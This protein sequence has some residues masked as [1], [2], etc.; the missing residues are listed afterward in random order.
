MASF[1]FLTENRARLERKQQRE[2]QAKALLAAKDRQDLAIAAQEKQALANRAQS[3][4]QFA[5]SLSMEKQKFTLAQQ[6][7]NRAD[8]YNS[9]SINHLTSIQES[10]KL[11]N[12][13]NAMGLVSSGSLTPIDTAEPGSVVLNGQNYKPT[14]PETLDK[15]KLALL[16]QTAGIQDELVKNRN[17]ATTIALS[18]FLLGKSP[19]L[20]RQKAYDSLLNIGGDPKTL[21]FA[22]GQDQNSR[23]QLVD[24]RLSINDIMTKRNQAAVEFGKD[25]PQVQALDEQAKATIETY[26]ATMQA[27]ASPEELYKMGEAGTAYKMLLKKSKGDD[28]LSEVTAHLAKIG[29]SVSNTDPNFTQKVSRAAVTL[30]GDDPEKLTNLEYSMNSSFTRP[31]TINPFGGVL[32]QAQSGQPAPTAQPPTPQPSVPQPQAALTPENVVDVYSQQRAAQTGGPVSKEQAKKELR[33]LYD[34]GAIDPSKKEIVAQALGIKN[35]IGEAAKGFFGETTA[36][37]KE[38]AQARSKQLTEEVF[39]NAPKN[40]DERRKFLA[41]KKKARIE[42]N[43]VYQAK[44][45]AEKEAAWKVKLD[46][47]LKK[48]K[49]EGEKIR[50][51]V[52]ADAKRKALYQ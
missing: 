35:A 34:Q 9:A 42:A 50:L 31:T 7:A 25:S 43:A 44:R 4:Q 24:M 28:A 15:R 10:N 12:Q 6:A 36:N 17:R 29:Q 23:L 27:S 37:I 51:E 39:G 21:A 22:I 13:L 19:S 52:E 18:S 40:I 26:H 3:A 33:V 2:M 32:G 1:P 38:E 20:M 47:Q 48:I 16:K 49:E 30:F 11:A 41:A 45:K 46:K 14:S 8:V 5:D